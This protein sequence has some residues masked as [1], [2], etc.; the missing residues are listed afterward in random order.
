MFLALLLEPVESLSSSSVLE[1]YYD[2]EAKFDEWRPSDDDVS[3]V[4]SPE[5][6]EVV[7]PDVNEIYLASGALLDLGDLDVLDAKQCERFGVWLGTRLN[8]PVPKHLQA[9]YLKALEMAKKASELGSALI[10]E[11]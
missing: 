5:G 4:Y 7:G 2:E 1:A 11:F 10:V 8:K 3:W 6:W 9:F